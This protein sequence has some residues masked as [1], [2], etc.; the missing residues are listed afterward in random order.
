VVLLY[1]VRIHFS[2][3]V[4]FLFDFD[5]KWFAGCRK[6]AVWCG[7]GRGGIG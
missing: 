6:K 4:F 2:F 7:C 5:S 1:V 3:D